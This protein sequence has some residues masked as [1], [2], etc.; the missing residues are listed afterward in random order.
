M[1]VA[2]HHRTVRPAHDIHN[3]SFWDTKE[4]QGSC[5]RVACVVQ[6]RLANPGLFEQSLPLVLITAWVYRLAVRLGEH[7]AA[8]VPLGPSVLSL[9][10]LKFTVFDDQGEELVGKGKAA[11]GRPGFD[12]DL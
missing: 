6:P 2:L 1:R 5:G 8:L 11:A 10:G 3:G 9:T 4:Q 12:L 7:P